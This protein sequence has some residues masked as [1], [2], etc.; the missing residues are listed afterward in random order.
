M[1]QKELSKLRNDQTVVIKIAD[2]GGAVVI[3][4]KGHYQNMKN[5]LRTKRAFKMK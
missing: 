5:I 4:S 3:L 1:K 2:K